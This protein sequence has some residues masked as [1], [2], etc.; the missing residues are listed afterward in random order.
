M[1]GGAATWATALGGRLRDRD[2]VT[3]ALV[4]R[5]GAVYLPSTPKGWQLAR[6]LLDH[7]PR[8]GPGASSVPARRFLH[9]RADRCLSGGGQLL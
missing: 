6:N 7:L 3:R 4:G 8:R 9:E 2:Q 1:P 5:A